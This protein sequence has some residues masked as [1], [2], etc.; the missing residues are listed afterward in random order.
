MLANTLFSRIIS[1]V[2]HW[3]IKDLHSRASK[4]EGELSKT[5]K[6]Q[7]SILKEYLH[8]S[9]HEQDQIRKDSQTHSSSIVMTILKHHNSTTEFSEAQH[10]Q[11]LDYLSA[12]LSIR[13]RKELIKVLCRGTPD[14]LTQSVRQLVDAYEPVIRRAHKAI[15]LS[16][17]LGDFEY[18]LKDLIKLGRIPSDKGTGWGATAGQPAAV[19]TVGDFVQLLRKHQRSCHVFLHQ[20]CKNDKELTG[21]YLEWAKYAAMQFKRDVD[22]DGTTKPDDPSI[23]EKGAGSLTPSLH[24]MFEALTEDKRRQ[25]IPVLDTHSEFLQKMHEQSAARLARVLKSPPS[26]SPAIAKIFSSASSRPVSRSSSPGPMA[27]NHHHAINLITSSSETTNGKEGHESGSPALVEST[28]PGPGAYLARWQ[29]LLDATA[30]TPLTP[31][32]PPKRAASPEVVQ[33]SATDVDGTK[34]VQFGGKE[35]RGDHIR[36]MPEGTGVGSGVKGNHNDSDNDKDKD[37][38]NAGGI[39]GNTRERQKGLRI[40]VEAMGD[41]FRKLLAVKGCNW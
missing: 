1:T 9:Q 21:W 29:A 19:P 3:D 22:G 30:I 2:L 36:V 8:K 32:G 39:G 13:D 4:I 14:H 25:I 17:T 11:L 34:M 7:L 18:F 12:R 31:S 38:T 37:K 27:H 24:R 28:S 33:N 41:D 10:K 5:A 40:V 23:T 16:A 6:H 35:A 15:D 26:K 20:C